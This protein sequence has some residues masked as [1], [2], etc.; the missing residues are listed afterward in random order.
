MG[1]RGERRLRVAELLV[2]HRADSKRK[3]R[4]GVSP[5]DLART[6]GG[7]RATLML[8]AR[9]VLLPFYAV[10][11][12]VAAALWFWARRISGRYGCPS[13]VRHVRWGIVATVAVCALGSAYG[14]VRAF[15]SAYGESVDP[16]NKAR[17]L[18]EGISESLNAAAL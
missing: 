15:G 5:L 10:V 16:S 13:W 9:P 17:V 14:M 1:A 12:P 11:V 3:N 8:V 6:M 18:A 4:S 2:G 7:A